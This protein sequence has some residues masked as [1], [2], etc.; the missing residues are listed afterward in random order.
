MKKN[1]LLM[2][3]DDLGKE[4]G[5]MGDAAAETPNLD[6]LA[7]D[8]V[9]F[10]QSFCT[11]AT[12]SASRS[13]IY[14]G[15]HNHQSGHYGHHHGC[16]HFATFDDVETIP[17]ILNDAGYLTA[18]VGKIHVGPD[19]VYPWQIRVTEDI[20]GARDV[21]AVCKAACKLIEHA[22]SED[23]PFFITLGYT[24]PHRGGGRGAWMNKDYPGVKRRKFSPDE[25][26]V[27][28]YLPDL[29]ETRGELAEYYESVNRLDQGVGMMLDQLEKLGHSDDT[30]V[31]FISD[32]GAPFINSKTT[33]YEPGINLPML[34]KTPGCKSGLRNPNMIS[35]I[36]IVPTLLDWADI[37]RGPDSRCMGRSILPIL[38][39]DKEL[40]D[41]SEINASHTFH[42]VTNY[43][44][45]RVLRGRKFKYIKNVIWKADFPFASDLY[46]SYTFEGIRKTPEKMI[47]KRPLKNYIQRPLEELYDL[48]NDIEEVNNLAGNP[49]YQHILEEMRGK[50]ED[51]QLATDDPWLFKDGTSYKVI[52]NFV[53][54]GLVI[55]DCHDMILEDPASRS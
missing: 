29:P 42:E 14:N 54:Q 30:L 46:A 12:C 11:T 50:V 43:Y 52:K 25:V 24:D 31:M 21:Q 3:A 13:V 8:G 26:N 7:K 45:C 44:P 16:H 47:G 4:T 18:I 2:I 17:A 35:Y 39:E 34:I 19:N 22:D 36:D 37:G 6:K 27:P 51:W 28:P 9:V 10:E 32:N 48:E 53:D 38:N 1:I 33:I 15:L 40:D 20:Q 5:F 41:W 49:E 23:K 55:P